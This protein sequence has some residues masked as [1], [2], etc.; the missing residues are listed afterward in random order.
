[1][2]YQEFFDSLKQ[3]DIRPVYVLEGEEEYIKA[4]AVKQLCAKLL[5]PGLETDEPDRAFASRRG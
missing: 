1:M 3:G 2:N 5:P 4:Q